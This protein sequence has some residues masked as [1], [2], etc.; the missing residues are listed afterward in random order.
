MIWSPER[1]Q[2]LRA[3]IRMPARPTK[4][5]WSPDDSLLAIG[6]EQRRS[7]RPE[8]R[9]VNSMFR[10]CWSRIA[11]FVGSPVYPAN[12]SACHP[13]NSVISCLVTT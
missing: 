10:T 6:S 7:V 12:D 1:K 5:V 2:P 11:S 9:S 3:T 13:P 4:L 8:K